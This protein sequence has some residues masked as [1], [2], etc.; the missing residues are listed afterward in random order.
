MILFTKPDCKKCDY[1]K[2][3]YNLSALRVEIQELT[4]INYEALALLCWYELKSIAETQLPILVLDDG[5]YITG[6]INI[7]KQLK[8]KQ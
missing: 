5:L 4:P 1:I 6:T 3:R 7:S 8:R 2:L